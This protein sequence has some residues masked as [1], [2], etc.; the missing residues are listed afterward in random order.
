MG[1]GRISMVVV[2]H[3]PVVLGH[4][5][6]SMQH[7]MAGHTQPISHKRHTCSQQQRWLVNEGHVLCGVNALQVALCLCTVTMQ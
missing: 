2:G 1:Q 6:V 4:T 3:I 5:T 7:L